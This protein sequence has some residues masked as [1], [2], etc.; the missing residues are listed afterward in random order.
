MDE[1]MTEMITILGGETFERIL[2]AQEVAERKQME[3]AVQ[4]EITARA[5]EQDLRRNTG[6]AIVQRLSQLKIDADTSNNSAIPLTTTQIR[7]GIARTDYAIID[8]VKLLVR[9]G[10]IDVDEATK[11]LAE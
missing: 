5:A 4:A 7:Q 10:V 2:T 6:K 11:L 8:L 9:T 3:A 1:P